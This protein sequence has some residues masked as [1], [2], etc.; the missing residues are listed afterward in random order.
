MCWL[1]VLTE[2]TSATSADDADPFTYIA[3]SV[4]AENQVGKLH[5]SSEKCGFLYKM[6][7]VNKGWK[8]RFF[9]L[10]PIAIFYFCE[11]QDE[12]PQVMFCV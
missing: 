5:E 10:H 12:D 1:T 8:R 7:F 9:T 2:P 6:G 4:A 11:Y 3:L